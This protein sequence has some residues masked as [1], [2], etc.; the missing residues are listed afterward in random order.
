MNENDPKFG[1]FAEGSSSYTV[2]LD[3]T[4]D[5]GWNN[6]YTIDTEK[7]FDLSKLSVQFNFWPCEFQ[8]NN[9]IKILSFFSM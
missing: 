8:S 5:I 6:T 9:Y 4:Q 7:V 1:T 2:T 3:P